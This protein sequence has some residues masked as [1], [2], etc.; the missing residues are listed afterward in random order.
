M[1]MAKKTKKARKRR[2]SHTH[3]R[4][5]KKKGRGKGHRGGVGMAGT[6][7][8]ADQKKT[9][10]LKLYGKK[11]FGKDKAL[12]RKQKPRLPE[13]SLSQILRNLDTLVKRGSA[14]QSGKDAFKLSFPNHK[15]LVG[16]LEGGLDKKLEIAVRECSARAK[17]LVEKAGGKVEIVGK[18]SGQ[19]KKANLN[20]N[21]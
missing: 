7:K 2:G 18:E 9:L 6:G 11:Y 5:F 15:L 13:I 8:R 17:E 19:G 20:E 1:K 21:N 3:G 4:G 16:K 10:V 14:Q 12:R